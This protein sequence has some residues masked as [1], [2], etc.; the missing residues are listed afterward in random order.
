MAPHR[1]PRRTLGPRGHR[2]AHHVRIVRAAAERGTRRGVDGRLLLRGLAKD[3]I[4][5]PEPRGTE[6]VFLPSLLLLLPLLRVVLLAVER[7][8]A[9]IALV[10]KLQIVTSMPLPTGTSDPNSVIQIYEQ[11]NCWNHNRLD[12][13]HAAR[14]LI[15]IWLG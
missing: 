15:P 11:A 13:R 12:L 7:A 1:H 6:S 8:K 3:P 5:G 14:E 10:F 9:C 4:G 2:T